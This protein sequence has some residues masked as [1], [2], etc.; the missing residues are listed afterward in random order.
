MLFW[1]IRYFVALMELRWG[2]E[3]A[4]YIGYRRLYRSTHVHCRSFLT[5][6]LDVLEKLKPLAT[7]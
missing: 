7:L 3:V 1:R 6:T 5:R 4:L 2:Y